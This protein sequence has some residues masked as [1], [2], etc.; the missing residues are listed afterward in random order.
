MRTLL[1]TALILIALPFA[2][3]AESTISCHCFQDRTYDHTDKS[4][5]DPFFLATAQNSLIAAIYGA[6]KRDLVKAR[7]SGIS[8]IWLWILHDLTVRSG[9]QPGEISDLYATHGNWPAVIDTLNLTPQQLDEPYRNK[10]TNPE[11]LADHIF[12]LQLIRYFRVD[13]ADLAV[14]RDR[15]MN[16]KELILAL[17]LD[18]DPVETYNKILSK[19]ATW[20]EL[21]AAKELADGK[22]IARALTAITTGE[23][24]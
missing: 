10:A 8:D 5:A 18:G 14:W 20:G 11:L 9:K 1:L 12:D 7:M 2:A 6:D 3:M 15:G 19:M 24:G 16:R 17:L 4:A 21:L 23:S 22:A 13:P